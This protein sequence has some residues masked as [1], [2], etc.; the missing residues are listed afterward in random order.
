MSVREDFFETTNPLDLIVGMY[1]RVR[2]NGDLACIAEP[3]DRNFIVIEEYEIQSSNTKIKRYCI[4]VLVKRG[5]STYK[6]VAILSKKL[7]VRVKQLSVLG[8]K[9][10]DATTVQLLCFPCREDTPVTMNLDNIWIRLVGRSEKCPS[11]QTSL[12]GNKFI[13]ILD[14]E[15]VDDAINA[16]HDLAQAKI[17]AYYGYQRFGIKRPNTHLLGYYLVKLDWGDYFRELFNSPYPHEDIQEILCRASYSRE[18]N[19]GIVEALLRRRKST[20]YEYMIKQPKWFIDI[21]LRALQA[22]IFNKYI[23]K[24]IEEG[25]SLDTK[26]SG[27]RVGKTGR[28]LAVVPGIGYKIPVTGRSRAILREVLAELSLDE[29]LLASTEYIPKIRPYWRPLYTII[30]E[31]KLEHYN[32][33]KLLVSFSLEKGM[34]ATT[35]L[36]EVVKVPDCI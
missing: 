18:C 13:I 22:I 36:R 19:I 10:T 17:P 25:Y 12:I 35:V 27:E 21:Q 1:Y 28:P 29:T 32:D 16:F 26:I 23:S 31:L 2:K 15:D 6:A 11:R 33:N 30:K 20:I 5:L 8:L 3:R 9:D 4:Y 14:V 24:R 34:Y 7:G